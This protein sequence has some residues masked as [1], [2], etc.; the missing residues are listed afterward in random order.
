[1]ITQGVGYFASIIQ[2]DLHFYNC[3]YEGNMHLYAACDSKTWLQ[4]M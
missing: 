3:G 4:N 1:M 2:V